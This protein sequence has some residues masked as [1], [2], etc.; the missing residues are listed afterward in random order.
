[1]PNVTLNEADFRR[2]IAG[3]VL[4]LPA[5]TDGIALADIGLEHVHQLL[6][7]MLRDGADPAAV[8]PPE[9]SAPGLPAHAMVETTVI[10]VDQPVHAW[11]ELSYAQ[12]LV[13]P[14]SVLQSMPVPW[15]QQFV[16]CM[17]ELDETIDWRPPPER[18]WFVQLQKSV[19]R[20]CAPDEEWWME[21]P[22]PLA[23]YE[24][25]RRRLPLKHAPQRVS[26]ADGG[27]WYCQTVADG[28][29]LFSMEFDAQLHKA[30][31]E[32]AI[33][34]NFVEAENP[35]TTILAREFDMEPYAQSQ[36]L[37]LRCPACNKTADY[38]RRD[39][40]AAI[41]CKHCGFDGSTFREWLA[42]NEEV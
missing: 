10:D 20:P 12:Y 4:S 11:F 8:I 36:Q 24:R 13:L 34:N 15:Q 7:E 9:P 42:H 40:L 22:D 3:Q 41:N 17:H 1:M 32:H 31:L 23:D 30:C 16:S 27:C 2:L 6:W 21:I 38:A 26:P 5:N 37:T 25:G 19:Q 29:W 14:R 33:E 28:E 39:S 35:E 18:R